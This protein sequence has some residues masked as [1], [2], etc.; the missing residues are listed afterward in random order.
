MPARFGPREGMGLVESTARTA[1]S[2]TSGRNST[3]DQQTNARPGRQE[4]IGKAK[5]L[6]GSP[7]AQRAKA[8]K[9]TNKAGAPQT[10]TAPTA[11]VDTLLEQL[12]EE[13]GQE[14]VHRYF[15]EKAR[16]QLAG[17]KLDIAVPTSFHADLIERRFGKKLREILSEIAPERTPTVEF[18]VDP[19]QFPGLDDPD[20]IP[21]PKQAKTKPSQGLARARSAKKVFDERYDLDRYVIGESNE[22]AFDAASQ[23]AD[24]TGNLAFTRL[25]LHSECGLGKTHLLRGIARRVLA[26]NPSARVRYVPAEAFTNEYIASV[27]AGNVDSFH[28]RYRGLDL[29]CLDDIHFLARKNA[30]QVE[31]LHTFDAIDLGGSR[32]VLASDGHPSQIE[33]LSKGLVNRF[34]SGLVVQIHTPDIALRKRLVCEFATR[35]GLR[36]DES[37]AMRLVEDPN[38]GT[39]S[40][41]ELEGALTRISAAAG[42]IT[43][44]T[45]EGKIPAHVIDRALSALGRANSAPLRAIRFENVRDCVC[46]TLEVEHKDLGASGRHKRVV[47]ARAVITLLCKKTTTLSYPEIARKMGK[48]NHS[49]VITAHQRI[50]KQLGDTVS[51]GLMADGMTI[52]QL[53][54]SIERRVRQPMS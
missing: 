9:A 23:I 47:M 51:L 16:V 46:Q 32:L 40:V 48:T 7:K 41:R 3:T 26:Q 21:Q 30:T 54:D 42:V 27:Q 28:K 50:E 35:R 11:F 20:L 31:L 33:S 44:R 49:T 18:R 45:P 12:C 2:T 52:Q 13:F 15:N 24:L 34:L 29:L 36:L 14:R 1:S 37:S 5:P 10:G 38:T 39:W 43:D 6:P 22:I 4:P 8:I 17:G 19:I 53:A 25:F